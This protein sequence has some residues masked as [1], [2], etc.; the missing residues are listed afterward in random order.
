LPSRWQ[1]IFKGFPTLSRISSQGKGS[2]A[3]ENSHFLCLSILNTISSH[4]KSLKILAVKIN[5]YTVT[6]L[7]FRCFYQLDRSVCSR[8]GFSSYPFICSF[9]DL[10][11]FFVFGFFSLHLRLKVICCAPI[12][13]HISFIYNISVPVDNDGKSAR[14][15]FLFL[16]YNK[17]SEKS[18]TNIS[19]SLFEMVYINT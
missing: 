15:Q 3:S 18:H 17:V 12:L 10:T 2:K 11:F 7:I 1:N 6:Y 8:V 5:I 4:K 9:S 13:L 16:V 14:F 19:H